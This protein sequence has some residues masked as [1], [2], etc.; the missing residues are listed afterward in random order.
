MAMLSA[1][2]HNPVTATCY[3]RR[4]NGDRPGKLALTPAT[5]KRPGTFDT[6]RPP[7]SGLNSLSLI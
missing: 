1:I 7:E 6:R 4:V 2:R 5:G 3:Q